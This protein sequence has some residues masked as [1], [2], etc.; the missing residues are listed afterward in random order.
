MSDWV[1]GWAKDQVIVMVSG[2]DIWNIHIFGWAFIKLFQ[3]NSNTTRRLQKN[4]NCYGERVANK[5]TCQLWHTDWILTRN[6]LDVFYFKS[7]IIRPINSQYFITH[8]QMQEIKSFDNQLQSY[9]TIILFIA[10]KKNTE[11]YVLIK[12]YCLDI[13]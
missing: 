2:D 11:I 10:R 12:L 7:E 3:R 4:N 5:T 13:Q 1:N 8:Y 6:M 9:H